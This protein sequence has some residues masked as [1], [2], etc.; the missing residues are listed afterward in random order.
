MWPD[1]CAAR[2]SM[3]R[4]WAIAK[5]VLMPGPPNLRALTDLWPSEQAGKLSRRQQ[6]EHDLIPLHLPSSDPSHLLSSLNMR[7][8]ISL[9]HKLN[10]KLGRAACL[11]SFR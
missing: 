2:L 11:Y 5:P 4:G 1:D 3:W 8:T 7:G 9:K 6:M 10:S